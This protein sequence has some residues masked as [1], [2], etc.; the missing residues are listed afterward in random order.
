MEQGSGVYFIILIR[1]PPPQ[2]KHGNY[3]GPEIRLGLDSF[4][5]QA[6]GFGLSWAEGFGFRV[7]GLRFEGLGFRGQVVRRL[8]LQDDRVFIA[9]HGCFK[10]LNENLNH[11]IPEP[12][13]VAKY[14]C[15]SALASNNSFM[16]GP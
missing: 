16:T 3:L 1:T 2:K 7:K 11:Q 13:A 5:L 8:L 9:R 6:Q 10:Q 4:Q 15:T 14:P 12:R